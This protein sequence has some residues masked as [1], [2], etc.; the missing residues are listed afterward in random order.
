MAT[1][2]ETD[3]ALRSRF[4][5]AVAERNAIREKAAPF[6]EAYEASRKRE[7][8][9]AAEQPALIS[10]MRAAQA[11]LFELD[12]EIGRIARAL[13]GKTGEPPAAA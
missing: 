10:A 11:G 2:E 7:Q 3:R 4:H 12:N 8:E 6:V 1:K 5:A 13:D 9:I